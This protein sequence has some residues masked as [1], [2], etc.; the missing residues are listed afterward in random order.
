MSI[1]SIFSP[2]VD[3]N[4]LHSGG[5]TL[6][7]IDSVEPLKDNWLMWFGVLALKW[8]VHL[9]VVLGILMRIFV[10]GEPVT[11]PQTDAAVLFWRHK[12]Q[13]DIDH[14]K[15]YILLKNKKKQ[16]KTYELTC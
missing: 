9:V 13:A 4:A 12:N 5:R 2:G 15:V 16:N 7:A 10:Y 6:N 8:T 1:G 11:R 3:Y 14:S